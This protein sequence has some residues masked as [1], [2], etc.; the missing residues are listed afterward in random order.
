MFTIRPLD[1][2][3]VRASIFQN[4]GQLIGN[5]LSLFAGIGL[6]FGSIA[7]MQRNKVARAAVKAKYYPAEQ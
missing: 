3:Y 1:V 6:R 5:H 2:S 7:T 4:G